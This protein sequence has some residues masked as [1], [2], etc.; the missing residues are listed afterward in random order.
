VSG[1]EQS[2]REDLLALVEQAR[3]IDELW[4]E[5]LELKRRLGRNS[6]NSSQPFSADGPAVQAPRLTR[7]RRILRVIATQVVMRLAGA[8]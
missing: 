4:A 7:R 3:M 5:V 8:A 2:S 1:S 6:R